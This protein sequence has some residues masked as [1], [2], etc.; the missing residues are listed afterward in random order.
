MDD[1]LRS[2]IIPCVVGLHLPWN[3]FPLDSLINNSMK[4]KPRE[5]HPIL[6]LV[7]IMNHVLQLNGN[8][9]NEWVV[10]L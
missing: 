7:G 2:S 9:G 6:L 1:N 10:K 5:V 4:W 3:S 8:M